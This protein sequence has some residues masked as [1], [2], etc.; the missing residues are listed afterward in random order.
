MTQLQTLARWATELSLADAPATTRERLRLQSL[1]VLGA[2]AAGCSAPDAAPVLALARA[3]GGGD[4]PVLPGLPRMD[5]ATGLETAAALSVA[6]DY[7]DYLLCGHTGHTAHWG[8]WLGGAALDR[9]WDEVLT[10]QLAANELMGRLGGYCL[11]GRQN[12]QAWAFLH[13]FGGALVGGLLR[14]LSADKLAH[15]MA[16]ALSR[17]PFVDWGTFRSGAKVLVAGEPLRAGWRAAALAEAGMEGPLG[18]LDKGSDFCAAFAEG[19]PLQGWMTGLGAAWL[20]ETITFKL[21]PGC[22]YLGTTL[23]ALTEL[24][25]EVQ[26][27]EGRPLRVD[28]VLRVDV[29]SGLLTAAMELLL[30]GPDKPALDGD[31]A[32]RPVETGFSVARS[33]ALL[34]ARGAPLEPSD[35]TLE[36]LADATAAAGDLPDR[37]HVHHD[38]RL[39][40]SAWEDLRERIGMDQLVAGLGPSTLLA[41][42]SRAR[43]SGNKHARD[44]VA[45]SGPP[46]GGT[47]L[48]WGE[49]PLAIAQERL[50]GIEQQLPGMRQ[51]SG[52]LVAD[53][54][55]VV[56]RGLEKI[57]GWAGRWASKGVNRLMRPRYDLG[58]YDLTGVGLP[59]PVRIKLL[60]HGG[61]VREAERLWPGGSPARPIGEVRLGVRAKFLRESL[62]LAPNRPARFERLADALVTETGDLP[63]LLGGPGEFLAAWAKA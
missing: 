7:D 45:A 12:G 23:E 8:S 15:A 18:I 11:G 37:V 5:L 41:T 6:L 42:A 10:A 31:A 4:L 16:I 63:E 57:A 34:L 40:L 62:R 44:G 33:V 53:P 29:D 36:A 52:E 32:L 47:G 60:E 35:F 9:S 43:R 54:G 61:R 48:A 25:A 38:W 20:T 56:G 26:E 2:T 46:G 17:A 1:S 39:T 21:V 22:A 59:V 27:Y 24:M 50:G 13:A 19:K 58:H 14:R 30:G 55:E 3:E 49:L 51:L 28:D